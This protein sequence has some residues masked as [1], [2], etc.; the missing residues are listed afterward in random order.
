[1]YKDWNIKGSKKNLLNQ[2]PAVVAKRSPPSLTGSL[3]L[4]LLLID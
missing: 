2:S 1:M 3:P 4:L